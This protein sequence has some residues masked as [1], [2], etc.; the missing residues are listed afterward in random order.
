M[1]KYNIE[2]ANESRVYSADIS[3][4]QETFLDLIYSNKDA[5][6]FDSFYK[7][8]LTVSLKEDKSQFD[9][10]IYAI[11]EATRQTPHI[12]DHATIGLKSAGFY[13]FNSTN[14]LFFSIKQKS[15]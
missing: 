11:T 10:H 13:S 2:N 9:H 15:S 12:K 1:S 4:N 3:F 7:D 8:A 5:V 6:G 14:S